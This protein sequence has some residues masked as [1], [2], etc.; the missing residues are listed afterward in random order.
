MADQPVQQQPVDRTFSVNS[1]RDGVQP[2]YA[3]P[4]GGLCFAGDDAE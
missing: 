3:I 1:L 2:S 4:I